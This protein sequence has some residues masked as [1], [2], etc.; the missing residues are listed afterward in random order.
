M[1]KNQF[2]AIWFALLTVVCDSNEA[3]IPMLIAAFF[4]VLWTLEG[5]E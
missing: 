1:S 3:W 4:Y 2:R 5:S